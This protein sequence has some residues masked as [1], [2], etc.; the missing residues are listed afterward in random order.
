[1]MQIV[2]AVDKWYIVYCIAPFITAVNYLCRSRFRW[3]IPTS[4][5]AGLAMF[6]ENFQTEGHAIYDQHYKMIESLVPPENLLR[7]HVK[8]GWKPLCEFLGQPVPSVPMPHVNSKEEMRL[9]RE[10]GT[11]FNL[12]ECGCRVIRFAAYVALALV[13]WQMTGMGL[14]RGLR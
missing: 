11:I 5:Q 4:H 12:T 7:Y 3:V 1:M 9:R 2:T 6:G 10:K 8:E 14:S 13:L